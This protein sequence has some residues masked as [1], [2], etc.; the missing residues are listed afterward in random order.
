MIFFAPGGC[1]AGLVQQAFYRDVFGRQRD[2]MRF[3][4]NEHVTLIANMALTIIELKGM[5]KQVGSMQYI[6]A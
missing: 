3:A 1:H 4:H 6:L 5:I 2:K